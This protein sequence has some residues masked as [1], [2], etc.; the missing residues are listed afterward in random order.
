MT[1][2]SLADEQAHQPVRTLDPAEADNTACRICGEPAEWRVLENMVARD[3]CSVHLR[4]PFGV[5]PY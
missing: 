2:L 1:Q 5:I 4:V 3:Y